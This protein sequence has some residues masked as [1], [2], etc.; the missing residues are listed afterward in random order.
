MQRIWILML[1]GHLFISCKSLQK[2][3][4]KKLDIYIFRS[5]ISRF[6]THFREQDELARV[7]FQ[8]I[9]IVIEAM[10]V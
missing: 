8:S 3:Q 5:G 7:F 4:T 6:S 2:Q 1:W 10:T 9:R